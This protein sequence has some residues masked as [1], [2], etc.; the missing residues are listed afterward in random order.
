MRSN[1]T[2]AGFAGIALLSAGALLA[3]CTGGGG[4]AEPADGTATITVAIDAGLEQEARDNF[5]A[6]VEE[7]ESDNP[8]ITVEAQEYTWTATTFTA[9]L[10]GGTLPDVFTIPFTDG[11]GLI[12]AEQIADISA[13]V[14][15][16]PYA[17]QFNPNVAQAG[18][19]EDG[20]QW[21]I[22]IAA[23]GQG[24]HYNRTLF[25][26]AGLDPDDP[27]TTWDEIRE[28]AKAITDA[29][30]EAGYA[31]MTSSNTGGW[32]LTT[33]ANAFGGRTESDDASEP[34]IDSD[35]AVAE[36]L[37]Y[38]HDLRWEDNSMGANF[39]Y[40][41]GTINQDFASGRI[42]MYVSG[43]GNYSNLVTQNA[44]NPDDYGLSIVPLQSDDPGLLGGGTLAAVSPNASEAEQAAAVK[45]IDFYY[46]AK[47]ADEDTAVE[48]A[49]LAASLD[50]P[51]GAP[52]LTIFDDELYA[53]YQS[54][55]APF[56]NVPVEQMAP[57][58]ENV[59]SQPLIAEPRT[60][61]QDVY[62]LLD[63]VVQ[64]V[65]TDENADIDQLLADAQAQAEALYAK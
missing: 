16:L 64:A 27:P 58:T 4:E 53:Q 63:V 43:G 40:D 45:W 2:R 24:L 10:A 38:L 20:S 26:A 48:T 41:W 25:E 49:E 36:V 1:I 44:L 62:A 3:G 42:G 28:A 5:D 52:E 23:Y 59:G 31:Q 39:L 21:A 17:D 57:Y 51:V 32:I 30:G 55:I 13:L 8:D 60:A 35:P 54:W 7:F 65:L 9:D 46:L 14:A 6:R 29:T 50:Q 34:T 33:V 18:Q 11:R 47:L 15:D 22:P 12:A 19:A 61:T 37:Q 56:V